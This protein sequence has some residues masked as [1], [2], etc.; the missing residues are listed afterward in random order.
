MRNAGAFCVY[1]VVFLLVWIFYVY[2]IYPRM[3]ALGVATLA[4]AVANI[5]ARSL[6]WVLP[7]FLFLIFV[8][9]VE[10]FDYLRLKKRWK[11]GLAVGLG[12]SL[13]ILGIDVLAQG[14]PSSGKAVWTWNNILSTSFLIGFFEEIPFRGFMLRKLQE[15]FGFWSA[16]VLSSLLFLAVH[17]PGWSLLHMLSGSLAVVI[18][19]LGFIFAIAVHYSRSLWSGIIAHSLN[20]AWSL[21]FL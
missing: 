13:V 17:I 14:A 10:P 5:A 2:A 1:L 7:V 18:F 9:R 11:T 16:N 19:A 8:D 6:L 12:L 15:Q 4:Y 20:D 21:L 3:I